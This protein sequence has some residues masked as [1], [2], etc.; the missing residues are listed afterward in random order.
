MNATLKRYGRFSNLYAENEQCHSYALNR[1][2]Y[3]KALFKEVLSFHNEVADNQN[4]TAVDVAC[5]SGQATIGL[6]DDFDKVIGIDPSL[7]QLS[8][9]RS[10]HKIEYINALAESTPLQDDSADVVTV[11]Q[12]LHWF[13]FE[14]F[15]KETK[16]ILKPNGT[17]AVWCYNLGEFENKDAQNALVELYSVG[18]CGYWSTRRT[19]IDDCYTNVQFPFADKRDLVVQHPLTITIR[20]Y[21]DFLA[22]WASVQNHNRQ[23]PD[24]TL[25]EDFEDT[26]KEIF[27]ADDVETFQVKMKW[28]MHLHLMRNDK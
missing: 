27:N 9:A 20:N 11:A 12:A 18:L 14:D 10:H 6:V 24:E 21:I 1:P 7:H 19:Y 23:N 5:G 25:L 26:L 13:E 2:A 3:S 4:L 22:T 15:F 8:N 28:P 17:L 16:R